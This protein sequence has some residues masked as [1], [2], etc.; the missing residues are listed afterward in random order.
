[1]ENALIGKMV[2]RRPNIDSIISWFILKW[3]PKGH[4]DVTA[5]SNRFF[6]FSFNNSKDPQRIVNYGPWFLKKL[7]LFLKKWNSKF[8]PYKE[9]INQFHDW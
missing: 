4:M 3:K 6:L 8:N 2:G 9:N 7:G 1:M 5:L